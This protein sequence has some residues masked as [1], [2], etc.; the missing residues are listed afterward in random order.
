[1]IAEEAEA[2]VLQPYSLTRRL[3]IARTH[4]IIWS[5]G[6]KILKKEY[7]EPEG[8]GQTTQI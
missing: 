4:Y 5:S 2:A 6:P 8:K 7:L 1:M 3:K